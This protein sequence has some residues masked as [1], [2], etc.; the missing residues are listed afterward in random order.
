M[1]VTHLIFAAATTAYIL[2]AIQFEERDLLAAHPEYG[3]YRQQVP[4]LMPLFKFKR[5]APSRVRIGS[6]S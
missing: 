2:I 5:R 3:A 4:M 1:T 6:E